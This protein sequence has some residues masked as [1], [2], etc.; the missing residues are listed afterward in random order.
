MK[1]GEDRRAAQLPMPLPSARLR[2]R[3][4]YDS[5]PS[6]ITSLEGGHRRSLTQLGPRKAT[7]G[8]CELQE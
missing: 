6:S 3:W 1:P 8:T 7:E 2:K 4:A 5:S